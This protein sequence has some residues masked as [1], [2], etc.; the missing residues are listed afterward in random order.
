MLFSFL[1][2]T[3][4]TVEPVEVLEVPDW[5]PDRSVEVIRTRD[6]SAGT[7]SR[8]RSFRL[9]RDSARRDGDRNRRRL[10]RSCNCK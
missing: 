4:L 2:A 9:R 7:R 1:I 6:V 5:E 8:S 10:S 3:A